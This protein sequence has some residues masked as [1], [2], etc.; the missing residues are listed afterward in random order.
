MDGYAVALQGRCRWLDVIGRRF[1]E[2]T[3]ALATLDSSYCGLWWFSRWLNMLAVLLCGS[4]TTQTIELSLLRFNSDNHLMML[5]SSD[6]WWTMVWCFLF[7]M[8]LF[9]GLC[10]LAFVVKQ[11]SKV[12]FTERKLFFLHTILYRI[13]CCNG[14]WFIYCRYRSSVLLL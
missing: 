8:C 11:P 7:L 14:H 13:H 4:D 3:F 1:S 5:L 2:V 9:S 10:A 12:R 6:T